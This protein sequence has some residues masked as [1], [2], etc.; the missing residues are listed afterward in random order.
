MALS[1]QTATYFTKRME[2]MFKKKKNQGC[3]VVLFFEV[4]LKASNVYSRIDIALL[5]LDGA[6]CIYLNDCIRTFLSIVQFLSNSI[7]SNIY[8]VL[9]CI[10]IGDL[11]CILA[12]IVSIYLF[13]FTE[14]DCSPVDDCREI[15][16]HISTKYKLRWCVVKG[17]MMRC[18][19][20]PCYRAQDF[21]PRVDVV[22]YL[23]V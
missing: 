6:V 14:C 7:G 4:R 19:Y 18:S 13:L 8:F 17:S 2:G 5:N 22:K 21:S 16:N 23:T 20:C 11:S 1:S 12:Q 10:I 15:K 9:L 3:T